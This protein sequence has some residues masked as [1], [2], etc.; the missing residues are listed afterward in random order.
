MRDEK[1]DVLKIQDLRTIEIDYDKKVFKVNGV[2]IGKTTEVIVFI[3][4]H[5]Q[6]RVYMTDKI[7]EVEISREEK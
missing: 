6:A 4:G 7:D 3:S 5:K 2:D 1:I